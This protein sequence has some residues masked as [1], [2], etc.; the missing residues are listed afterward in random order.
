MR[1]A[2]NL[3]FEGASMDCDIKCAECDI[4]MGVPSN[5]VSTLRKI[6]SDLAEWK[7][8]GEKICTLEVLDCL[9]LAEADYDTLECLLNFASKHVGHAVIVSDEQGDRIEACAKII[10]CPTCN[11]GC[12]CG[13]AMGHSGPCAVKK[14]IHD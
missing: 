4:W 1:R 13:L 5:D 14:V 3:L 8:I 9:N 11:S 2:F 7:R 6:V 10:S 12:L